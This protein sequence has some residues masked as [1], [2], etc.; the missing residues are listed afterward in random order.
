MR[1]RGNEATLPPGQCR[2]P[3]HCAAGASVDGDVPPAH[4]SASDALPPVLCS[5]FIGSAHPATMAAHSS[6]PSLLSLPAD[7]LERVLGLTLSLG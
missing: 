6:T 5:P 1:Q 3:T 2:A 7:V 4:M